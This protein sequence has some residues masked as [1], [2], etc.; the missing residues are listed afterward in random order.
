LVKNESATISIFND[1]K[2]NTSKVSVTSAVNETT[3]E[4]SEK[5]VELT[6]E[7]EETE[8]DEA[9]IDELEKNSDEELSSETSTE[10]L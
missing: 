3:S 2:A 8:L 10:E 5:L 7:L 6:V 9:A 1:P 4:G